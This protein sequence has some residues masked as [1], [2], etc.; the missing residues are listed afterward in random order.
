MNLFFCLV[1]E[2]KAL[3]LRAAEAANGNEMRS[4][5][6]ELSGLDEVR[7]VSIKTIFFKFEFQLNKKFGSRHRFGKMCNRCMRNIDDDYTLPEEDIS[8][9]GTDDGDEQTIMETQSMDMPPSDGLSSAYQSGAS[10]KVNLFIYFY[11]YI[12][13]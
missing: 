5:H 8:I 3:Q 12:Y 11:L 13:C 10:L 7:F 4:M 2:N 1:Q 9:A 6:D